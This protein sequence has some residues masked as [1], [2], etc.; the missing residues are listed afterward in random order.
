MVPSPAGPGA[1]SAL[2]ISAKR[3]LGGRRAVDRR[4]SCWGCFPDHSLTT[5]QCLLLSL[6]TIGLSFL[7]SPGHRR[8]SYFAA[9]SLFFFVFLMK[10]F[11]MHEQSC[12][13]IIL[14]QIYTRIYIF[15]EETKQF[16]NKL[17]EFSVYSKDWLFR[18]LGRP[19]V[20]SRL[21]AAGGV[22]GLR[23]SPSA[24]ELPS[25]SRPPRAGAGY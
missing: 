15:Q 24:Q 4:R 18:V 14:E 20:T 21:A 2:S 3:R 19:L 10:N 7:M 5:E 11:Q 23:R 16:L 13:S 12:R 8:W 6:G 17:L 9:S 25:E 1:A 22:L